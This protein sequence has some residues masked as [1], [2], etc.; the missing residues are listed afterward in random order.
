MLAERKGGAAH[1]NLEYGG[2]YLHWQA[3]KTRAAV[4]AAGVRLTKKEGDGATPA[5]TFPLPFGMYRPDRIKLPLTNLPMTP[6]REVHAWVDDGNDPKYNQLVELPYPAHTENMWRADGIY[7]LLVVVGYNMNPTQ[8][9][10]GSAIFLHI[11]RPNFAPTEGCLAIE[12]NVL[13]NLVTLL[14][15]ESTLTIR[16]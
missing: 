13:L 9:G 6:L 12:R 11:A 7:D 14:G 4:G 10:A 15:P 8:P 1:V 16:E 2:G 3:R 5:G